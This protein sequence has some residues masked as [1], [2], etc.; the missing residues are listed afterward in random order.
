M[1]KVTPRLNS[2]L[3]LV[4]WLTTTITNLEILQQNSAAD[5]NINH[6]W[7]KIFSWDRNIWSALKLEDFPS[8]SRLPK[9]EPTTQKLW[10]SCKLNV[11]VSLKMI[12][13]I[14]ILLYM[15]QFP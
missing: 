9:L 2:H 15:A 14:Y 1:L 4:W 3:E 12:P 13:G 6:E 7:W 8:K 11:Y 10:P 5:K